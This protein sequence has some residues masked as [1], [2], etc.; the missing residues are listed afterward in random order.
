MHKRTWQHWWWYWKHWEWT[1][2]E[3]MFLYVS[4]LPLCWR[5]IKCDYSNGGHYL[6]INYLGA[7]H[8]DKHAYSIG[9][10]SWRAFSKYMCIIYYM[11]SSNDLPRCC[12]YCLLI[13]YFLTKL[14]KKRKHA[15]KKLYISF[16]SQKPFFPQRSYIWVVE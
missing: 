16:C 15:K 3:S 12:C 2:E 11:G 10:H 8:A 14:A 4:P 5:S 7:L 13:Y 6:N 9:S 1:C